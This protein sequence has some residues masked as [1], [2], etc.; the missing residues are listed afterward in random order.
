[1]F[2]LLLNFQEEVLETKGGSVLVLI[3]H[4][5]MKFG[6]IDLLLGDADGQ[7]IFI[8]RHSI[9]SRLSLTDAISSISVDKRFPWMYIGNNAG[10][11]HCFQP[12]NDI[13]WKVRLQDDQFL[14]SQQTSQSG[15]VILHPLSK[16]KHL[17]TNPAIRC[18]YS[19]TLLDSK[20]IPTNV[21][22]VCDGT[23]HIHVYAQKERDMSIPMPSA[24]NSV[25]CFAFRKIIPF[26]KICCGAFL[27]KENL[28][29]DKYQIAAA[30]DD[31]NIYLVYLEGKEFK[32]VPFGTVGN[33]VVEM[34]VLNVTHEPNISALLC[35]GHFNAFLIFLRGKVSK[36]F[37]IVDQKCTFTYKQLL[38]QQKTADWVHTISIGDINND[39]KEEIVVGLMNNTVEAYKMPE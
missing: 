11:V 34:Q 26:I 8:S 5:I 31:G 13:L 4:D 22:L 28:E 9:L 37:Y 16:R 15:S 36:Y 35:R 12:P 10:V 27:E 24:V 38:V 3:L 1:M 39:G 33:I 32:V 30:C 18:L 20:G 29:I 21:L 7:L 6:A 23:K 17:S 14:A 2:S 19:T 25:S